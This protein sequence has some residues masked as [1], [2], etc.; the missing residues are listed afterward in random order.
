MKTKILAASIVVSMLM[1]FAG[2]AAAAP[3]SDGTATLVSAE[4]GL[5]G[6]VFIFSV[7]GDF[8]R[9][10]LNGTAHVEGGENYPLSCSQLEEFTVR[11]LTS[12]KTGG[13][14]VVLSW[15]G[16]VFWTYVPEAPTPAQ[17]CYN[18]YDFD[19]DFIWQSYGVYCQDAPAQYGDEIPWYNPDW[20]DT[21]DAMF[22]PE[23]PICSGIVEDAYYFVCG[24]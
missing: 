4:H 19:L 16:F 3:L 20:D 24:F 10:E 5:S 15:G 6:A 17:Y 22:L 21:F 11:C 9:S 2:T 18:V 12:E 23:G 13:Q 8:S 14:N 1:M 7:T